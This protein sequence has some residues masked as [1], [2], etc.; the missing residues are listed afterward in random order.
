MILLVN[1]LASENKVSND[2]LGEIYSKRQQNVNYRNSVEREIDDK[3][4][5]E[6]GLEGM[7]RVNNDSMLKADNNLNNPS[8]SNVNSKEIPQNKAPTVLIGY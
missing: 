6:E 2:L 1:G 5:S 4:R 7:T 8:S 3:I